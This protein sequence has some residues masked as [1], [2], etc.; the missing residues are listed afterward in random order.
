[1]FF[2]LSQ[3]VFQMVIVSRMFLRLSSYE[4]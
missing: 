1:L 3:S 2:F 4:F